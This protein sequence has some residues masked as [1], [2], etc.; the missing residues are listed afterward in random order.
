MNTIFLYGCQAH[1]ILINSSCKKICGG[2]KHHTLI[3]N[4]K[5]HVQ[6]CMKKEN[7]NSCYNSSNFY[8]TSRSQLIFIFRVVSQSSLSRKDA[9]SFGL[10]SSS[11]YRF[12][13]PVTCFSNFSFAL[14]IHPLL[15]L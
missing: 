13:L 15:Q 2:R 3:L 8:T 9:T 14:I 5:L 12:P 7:K 6:T 4:I 10:S 11:F 1:S